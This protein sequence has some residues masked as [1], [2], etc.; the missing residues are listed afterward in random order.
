MIGNVI[1]NRLLV[2]NDYPVGLG[3]VVHP[4]G[5]DPRRG[6]DLCPRPGHR[7]ADR[8]MATTSTSTTAT[9][10]ARRPRPRPVAAAVAAD[11]PLPAAGVHAPRD[12]LPADPDRRDDRVLVQQARRASSTTP[13]TS[14][15]STAGCTRST[16]RACATRWSRASRVA[17][18]ATIFAT[19]LGTM[20]GL[21]LTRYRFRG[22]GAAQRPHL[23]A[24]G[25]ARDRHG[26]EPADA[27][28]RDRAAARSR[29]PSRSSTRP[30]ST[31]SSS[32]TSCSAS[33]SWS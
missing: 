30:G 6:G 7:A 4:H 1:Q 33:A 16:G 17:V 32:P 23:P 2:Q 28:R 31:R 5:R 19:I 25:D 18:L 29:A 20:I 8:L 11:R 24:D 10:P 26:R 14:S 12:R 21:A 22:R 27:V 9:A 15:R 3:A 13:G